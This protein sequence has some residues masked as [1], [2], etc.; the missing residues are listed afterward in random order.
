MILA[1]LSSEPR[2]IFAWQF[3]QTLSVSLFIAWPFLKASKTYKITIGVILW[4]IN[5]F[6]KLSLTPYINQPN[7]GGFIF[8]LLY[9]TLQLDGILIFFTFFLIGMVI[10][11]IIFEVFLIEDQNKRKIALKKRLLFPSCTIGTIL[12]I[13]GIIFEFPEFL[14]ALFRS[15]PWMIYSLG[16]HLILISIFISI[17]DRGLFQTKKNYKFLFYFSYYSFTVYG[18]HYLLTL[19][20]NRQLNAY[21]IWIFIFITLILF[22]TLFRIAYKTLKEK[23]SLKIQINVIS[24]KLAR[25]IEE[26]KKN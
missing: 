1:V 19:I 5:Y 25:I 18:T 13:I 23:I 9:T 3:L 24:V 21:N 2:W 8:V 4:I 7:I 16:I 12:L 26:R 15:S 10:G 20:F 14:N 22:N 6:V 17:E 11:E